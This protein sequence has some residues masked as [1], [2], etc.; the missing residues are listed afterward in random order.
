MFDF[1]F[2]E[3]G[4]ATSL[5]C[6]LLWLYIVA[7]NYRQGLLKISVPNPNK[8]HT[9]TLVLIAFFF[10]THAI[11]GDFFHLQEAVS[12]YK[13]G[14]VYQEEIY[15][16]IGKIVGYNY[17]L[18]R[19]IVWGGAFTLFCWTS[20]RFNTPVYQ[21]AI[22]LVATQAIIFGYARVTLAM[23]VYFLGLSFICNPS[24]KFKLFERIFGIALICCSPFFHSSAY[25]MVAATLMI[26]VPLRKWIIILVLL[27]V[28]VLIKVL[29]DLFY[30]VLFA[31]GDEYLTAKMENYTNR[32]M[33]QRSIASRIIAFFQYSSY[34]IPLI[35]ATISIFGKQRFKL[36]STS[37]LRLYKVTFGIILAAS[38]F[39]LLGD[40]FYTFFYRVLYMSMIPL[41]IIMVKLYQ[42]RMLSKKWF[43]IS[44]IFGFTSCLLRY[45][46]DVYLS[47]VL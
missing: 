35:I 17:F 47:I 29:E 28:P 22:F 9:G 41:S 38:S 1:P 15:G 21:T 16:W 44:L 3:A 2:K 31:G 6:L 13:Y 24:G 27:C 19:V 33:G 12:Q 23:A 5:Y 7:S 34:Y 40:M 8:K 42:D 39:Y 14:A 20:K 37:T 4:V 46:Y 10:I 11:Q 26:F 45:M 32:D 25:L 30:V 18:F 43:K 36:I